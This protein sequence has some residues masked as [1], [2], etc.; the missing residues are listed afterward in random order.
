LYIC[1]ELRK[2]VAIFLL[3]QIVSNNAFAEGLIK[4]PRLVSHYIH[5]LREHSNT[6]SFYNFLQKHYTDQTRK[7]IHAGKQHEEDND[8][9]MPFKDCGNCC[10]SLHNLIAGF[11]SFYLDIDI[12]AFQFKKS[13]YPLLDDRIESLDLSSIWQPPKIS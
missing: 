5:D 1:F 8:C 9:G 6:G 12:V 10:I 2:V 3:L 4:M 11:V 13:S 7:D